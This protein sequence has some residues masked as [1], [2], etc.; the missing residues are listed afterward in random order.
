MRNFTAN[1]IIKYLRKVLQ[2]IDNVY[3]DSGLKNAYLLKKYLE[4]YEMTD[5]NSP[6]LV[7]LSMLKDIGTFYS[8]N[9]V[10][11][12][13][14]AYAAASSYTFLKY[15]SPLGDAA[16][17]LMFYKARY[18][19]GMVD[20]DDPS[21]MDYYYGLLMT[22]INQVILYNYMEYSFDEITA[23]IKADTKS[24]FHPDQVRKLLRMLKKDEEVLEKLNSTSSLY[25]YETT[26]YISQANYTD[27]E[28]MGFIETTNYVFEFHNHE[29]LA[30]TVTTAEIA[31]YIAHKFRLTEERIEE[32]Y[33]AG[34][35]HDIGKIRIPVNIL[36]SPN[37]LEGHELEIMQ[38][39]VVYTKEILQGNFSDGVIAIASNH[40][41]RVDG[42]GYPNHLVAKDL[43][44][45]DKIIQVSDVASALYSKRSY[46]NA[47]DEDEIIE[48]LEREAKDNKLD[49]RVVNKFIDNCDEII[50]IAKE[51]EEAVLGKYQKMKDQYA[52]LI[53]NEQLNEFFDETDDSVDFIDRK[54]P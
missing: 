11:R 51:R 19:E 47:Y 21:Y 22:L 1:T 23:L 35:V 5:E 26:R 42:S 7:L 44:I 33:I 18:V 25:V 8:D 17:P 13:N 16:R 10:P 14:H 50:K 2:E 32:I 37:R 38:Q 41:E 6:K 49:D 36:T 27:E 20:E 9:S 45:G 29:T 31:K 12:E 40:H 4:Y 46:K 48:E 30:H 28:L 52:K 34:L 24:Q 43:S 39:H 3:I 15:C 54:K 53:Q